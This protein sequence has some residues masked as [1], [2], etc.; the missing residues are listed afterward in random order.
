LRSNRIQQEIWLSPPTSSTA[1]AAGP[2]QSGFALSAFGLSLQAN[3]EKPTRRAEYAAVVTVAKLPHYS[4]GIAGAAIRRQLERDS[5]GRL[6]PLQP[7]RIKRQETDAG[8][9]DAIASMQS[10]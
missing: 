1:R 6:P 2:W 9:L 5:G 3:V 8:N 10:S 4:S 7:T